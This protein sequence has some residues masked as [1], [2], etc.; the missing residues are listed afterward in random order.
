MCLGNAI[1]WKILGEE[2]INYTDGENI[3]YDDS[4]LSCREFVGDTVFAGFIFDQ[5]SSR[6]N[7]LCK[8]FQ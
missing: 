5:D 7:L 1:K 6:V 8:T 2:N 3:G 4:R